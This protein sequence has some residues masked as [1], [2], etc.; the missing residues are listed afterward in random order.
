MSNYR[1]FLMSTIFA[2]V[3]PVLSKQNAPRRHPYGRHLFFFWGGGVK[4]S[5]L[6]IFSRENPGEF[7][8][9]LLLFGITHLYQETGPAESQWDFLF[10]SANIANK[11]CN[12]VAGRW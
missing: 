8:H 5:F 2:P 6:K 1:G 10:Y 11:S 7:R 12:P 3:H 4:Q 9:Y